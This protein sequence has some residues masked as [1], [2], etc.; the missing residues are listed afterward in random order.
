MEQWHHLQAGACRGTTNRAVLI[1][2]PRCRVP[3]LLPLPL[4][5]CAMQSGWWDIDEH[6]RLSWTQAEDEIGRDMT[7]CFAAANKLRFE[8]PA[9]RWAQHGKA[10]H[11][12][13]RPQRGVCHWD[14]TC[15]HA[16]STPCTCT[17]SWSA[18]FAGGGV[19]AARQ[20]KLQHLC[21]SVHFELTLCHA[22]CCAP[23]AAACRAFPLF[24]RGW[25]NILHED[26][27][28]GVVA[29]ERVSEGDARVVTVIN[30]GGAGSWRINA[31]PCTVRAVVVRAVVT[32]A[33][34]HSHCHVVLVTVSLRAAPVT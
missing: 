24:R 26:R 18:L 5:C 4:L 1:F 17:C 2:F 21:C 34:L 3:V 31:V 7:A 8:L 28:N 9:L 22:A 33:A 20:P 29:F 19:P 6:H 32:L 13:A 10:Q 11:G 25:A 30:A 27:G 16:T 23:C 12:A 15:T 14:R